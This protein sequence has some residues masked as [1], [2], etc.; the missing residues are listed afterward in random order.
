MNVKQGAPDL[1]E[2]SLWPPGAT[3]THSCSMQSS[4]TRGSASGAT[5]DSFSTPVGEDSRLCARGEWHDMLKRWALENEGAAVL[6]EWARL[7]DG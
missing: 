7:L 6:G 5:P 1:G 4:G 3:S 2:E